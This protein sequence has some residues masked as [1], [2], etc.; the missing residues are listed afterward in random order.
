MLCGYGRKPRITLNT[1]SFHIGVA[2]ANEKIGKA[3]AIAAG[4]ILADDAIDRSVIA[5]AKHINGN[6]ATTLFGTAR[7]M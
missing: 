5:K 3:T 4:D 2:M 6:R 7:P 1:F